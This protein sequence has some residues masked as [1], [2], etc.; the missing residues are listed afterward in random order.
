[1][2]LLVGNTMSTGMRKAVYSRSTNPIRKIQ[3]TQIRSAGD[4]VRMWKI[5]LRLCMPQGFEKHCQIPGMIDKS[6]QS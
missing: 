6:A 4:S 2:V 5:A 3:A 1:M